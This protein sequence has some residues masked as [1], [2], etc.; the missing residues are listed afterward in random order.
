MSGIR[1]MKNDDEVTAWTRSEIN[2]ARGDE[3]LLFL[4]TPW[5][6]PRVPFVLDSDEYKSVVEWFAPHTVE[7]IP[8]CPPAR[9]AGS[10]PNTVCAPQDGAAPRS[11]ARPGTS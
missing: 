10:R 1:Q 5:K 4:V 7:V 8:A 9:D 11:A 3:P 2:A 6:E